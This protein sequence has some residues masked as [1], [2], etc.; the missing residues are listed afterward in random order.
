MEVGALGGSN[1][2]VERSPILK[3]PRPQPTRT[4]SIIQY[5]YRTYIHP[6]FMWVCTKTPPK[7]IPP[8]PDGQV[9]PYSNAL[10]LSVYTS[11]ENDP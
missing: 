3:V 1:E 5:R 9:S 4:I 6:T 8:K 7:K 10:Q 2:S 11:D